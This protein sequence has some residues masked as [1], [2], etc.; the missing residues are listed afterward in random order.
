MVGCIWDVVA[1][2]C[3]T[4]ANSCCGRELVVERMQTVFRSTAC[5]E[6]QGKVI[7]K[8]CF[9]RVKN[10]KKVDSNPTGVAQLNSASEVLE[11]RYRRT[12]IIP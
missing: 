6:G 4:K 9:V 11:A 5:P 12:A 7:T 3:T 8:A 10:R 1:R 2:Y